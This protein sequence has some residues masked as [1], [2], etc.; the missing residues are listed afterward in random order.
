M[1]L[2][3][4]PFAPNVDWLSCLHVAIA[5]SNFEGLTHKAL[6]G[7]W[8]LAGRVRLSVVDPINLS[9]CFELGAPLL[10]G[11]QHFSW[12][13]LGS[14]VC[15]LLSL[16]C[17]RAK[18]LDCLALKLRSGTFFSQELR[19]LQRTCLGGQLPPR[20]QRLLFLQNLLQVR[21]ELR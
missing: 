6:V 19:I 8:T 21:H 15:E 5:P 7:H 1:Y 9:C 20:A 16:S 3:N 13:Q 14:V 18:R 2:L 17:W 12:G 11:S 4:H 10:R